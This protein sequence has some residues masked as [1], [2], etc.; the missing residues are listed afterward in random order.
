MLTLEEIENI[1]FHKSGLGGYK[2]DE[3]EDFVDKV[4]KKVKSLENESREYENRIELLNKQIQEFKE[5]EDTV[6]SAIITAQMTAKQIVMDATEKTD[7]QLS[8]SKEK[9]EKILN[10]SKEK[11]EKLIKESKERAERLNAETDKK[12]EEKYNKALRESAEK[13]EE[14][15]RI[16]DAQKKNIIKLMGE[17]NNFRNSLLRAYKQH[18]NVINSMAKGDD[19][20]KYQKDL[21]NNY[22][23]MNGNKP[24][25]VSEDKT[26]LA[27]TESSDS[28]VS[29]KD[30]MI[31]DEKTKEKADKNTDNKALE[32]EENKKKP[33]HTPA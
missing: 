26:P 17:A 5:K 4:I 16:L 27:E 6:Q 7:K 31:S 24:L 9:A 12:I 23:A 3:V 29:D 22:P 10:E 30:N 15:N 19:F 18:L 33:I 13:I 14:N 1:S 11:S 28:M 25:P 2:M 21:E 32:A 8:E 20:R